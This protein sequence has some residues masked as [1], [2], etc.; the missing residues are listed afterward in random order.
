MKTEKTIERSGS[1]MP[2]AQPSAGNGSGLHDEAAGVLTQLRAF[3]ATRDPAPGVRLPPE[4]ELAEQL[5]VTRA[6]LRKG[7]AALEAEGLLWRQVGKGTFFGAKPAA[8]NATVSA[9]ARTTNPHEVMRARSALEPEVTRLAALNAT[10]E[11]IAR[12]KSTSARCRQA[13]TWRQYEAMD[14]L[15]HHQIASASHN[16]LLIGLLDILNAVRRTVTWGRLRINPARP[17]ADHHSFA[18]H[19]RIIGAIAARDLA[20][21]EA[22]MRAHIET[23]TRK[24]LEPDHY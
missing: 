22:A 3:I 11:E 15:L 13:E 10:D 20:G 23:V 5:G 14:A 7:L 9:L 2:A 1:E 12:L 17:P 19:D 6:E 8:A 18:E 21:A 24:L 16:G 4:R